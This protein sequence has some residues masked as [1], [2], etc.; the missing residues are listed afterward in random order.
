MPNRKNA[1]DEMKKDAKRAAVNRSARNA[2]K[3]ARKKIEKVI[4]A[5]NEQDAK[6]ALP[7]LFAVVDKSAK[8]GIIPKGRASRIKSTYALNVNKLSNQ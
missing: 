3:T 8:K 5:G 4:Q 6:S 7:A 1:Q 2:L